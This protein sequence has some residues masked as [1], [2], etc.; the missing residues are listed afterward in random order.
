VLVAASVALFITAAYWFNAST[1]FANPA[2]TVARA[3]SDTFA[4]VRPA[5]V[6]FFLVGQALG[7]TAGAIAAG[8]LIRSATTRA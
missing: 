6:P 7:T 5:D 3:L 1:S 2:V 8:Y 4:G